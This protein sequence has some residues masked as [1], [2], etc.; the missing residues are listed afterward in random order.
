PSFCRM[1]GRVSRRPEER[2]VAE[3]EQPDVTDQEVECARKESEA[4][5]LHQEDRIDEVRRHREEGDHHH[6]RD[7][8][9]ANGAHWLR[10]KRPVGRT[11]RTSAMIT[12]MTV[13]DASG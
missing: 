5:R 9:M 8:L 12:K 3:R 7:H 2:R 10:P 4:Q 11:S 1:R 6:E 13:L